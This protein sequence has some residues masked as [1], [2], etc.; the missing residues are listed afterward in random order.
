M[1]NKIFDIVMPLLP[2]N[3]LSHWVGRL[4]HRPLPGPLARHSVAAFASYFKIDMEEAEHPIE[5]YKTIGE[6]FTRKLKPGARPVGQGVVHPTD[7]KITEAGPIRDQTLIQ[8]KGRNYHV[9][10]LLRSEHFAKDFEGGS[11]L[12]YYLCPTDYHRVHSPVDG[13]IFW[14]SHVPGLLWPV[15]AWSVN[16]VDNLFAINERIVAMIQTPKG[17]AA[18]VMVAATNVGNMSVSFDSN[19]STKH[20]TGER[21]VR[22]KSYQPTIAIQRGDEV[23]IFHMG[24]TVV[25]LYEKSVLDPSIASRLSGQHVEM[26]TSLSSVSS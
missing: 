4:V 3:E 26:G 1:K 11:F 24:S 9:A 14:S 17:K 18:L 25:M 22:E 19:I 6:L 2:K 12:T 5:H 21:H 23:G 10:E 7:S 16:A 8:A 13:E 20:R 15:N